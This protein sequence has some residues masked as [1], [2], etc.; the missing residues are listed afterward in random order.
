MPIN[1]N[2]AKPTCLLFFTLLLFMRIDGSFTLEVYIKPTPGC[3]VS[4]SGAAVDPY[5]SLMVAMFSTFSLED[6]T[7][8]LLKGAD[9]HYVHLAEYDLVNNTFY[10]FLPTGFTVTM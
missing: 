4:C 3:I 9:D 2:L 5:F 1:P 7:F 6:V 10:Y 8:I